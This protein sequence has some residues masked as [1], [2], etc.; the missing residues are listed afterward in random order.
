MSDEPAK[1]T[2]ST[3]PPKFI[4][5]PARSRVV[6][7]EWPLEYDGREYSSVTIVKLNAKEVKEV[8]AAINRG[9]SS[10]IPIFRDADG[11]VIP[12]GVLD[13]LDDDDSFALDEAAGEFIP[14]RF[15]P[16]KDD[17]ALA[18]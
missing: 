5:G 17:A 6:P 16:E 1:Q 10:K 14:R 2:E 13:A 8:L 9:E 4:G 7:L 15:K 12:D 11:G 18:A 3:A